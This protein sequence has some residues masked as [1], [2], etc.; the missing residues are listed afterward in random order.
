M[1]QIRLLIASSNGRTRSTALASPAVRMLSL[2]A[3]ATS[4]R[5]N[6][7][8]AIDAAFGVRRSQLLR[9]ARHPG[10]LRAQNLSRAGRAIPDGDLVTGLEQ[11]ARHGAAYQTEADEPDLHRLPPLTICKPA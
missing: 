4:G 5:P 2:P 3:A 6:I 9:R 10:A 11:V 7:G 1:G 8:A